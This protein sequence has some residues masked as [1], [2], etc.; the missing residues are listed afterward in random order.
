MI[1]KDMVDSAEI[2]F[3]GEVYAG[4][5]TTDWP[6]AENYNYFLANDILYEFVGGVMNDS[7]YV[8]VI[9]SDAE[10]IVFDNGHI[11][12]VYLYRLT[13]GKIWWEY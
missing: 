3:S 6:D 12:T 7:E 2:I 13:N 11:G 9:Q 10:N 8:E 5:L 1:T 4:R